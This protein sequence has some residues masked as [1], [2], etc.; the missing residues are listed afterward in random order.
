MKVEGLIP[1]PERKELFKLNRQK[2]VPNVSGCYV[3][4]NFGGEILYIGLASDLRRRFGQH[5]DSREKIGPT[6]HG[7]AYFFYWLEG[8]YLEKLERTWMN[9]HTL[10]EGRLPCLNKVSSPIRM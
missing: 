3:L 10:T 4:T 8:A 2:F 1:K 6:P 7:V 5:L 9:S